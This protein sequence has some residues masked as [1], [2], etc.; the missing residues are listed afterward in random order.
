MKTII[1]ILISFLIGFIF[2]SLFQIIQKSK[3]IYVGFSCFFSFIFGLFWFEFMQK[4]FKELEKKI[5]K[6]EKKQ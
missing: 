4:I 2:I 5:F 3:Y 6:N 1:I